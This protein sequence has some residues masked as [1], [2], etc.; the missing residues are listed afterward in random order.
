MKK[1]LNSG[2]MCGGRT[3]G[4]TYNSFIKIYEYAKRMGFTDVNVHFID[5]QLY[6][7]EKENAHQKKVIDRLS[8]KIQRLNKTLGIISY[9]L[10][11]SHERS[12]RLL[13]QNIFL[14]KRENK[15]QQIEQI[16]KSG[17]VDL[18]ELTKLVRGEQ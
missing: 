5:P 8:R 7:L 17:T 4:R 6:K 18:G 2:V 11:T 15:L 14:I 9:S 12:E 1:E 16:F 13:S 10:D 3:S